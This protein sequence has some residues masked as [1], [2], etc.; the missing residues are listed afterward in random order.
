MTTA[1]GPGIGRDQARELARRELAR[2]IYR[3]SLLSR[4]GHDIARWLSSLFNPVRGGELNWLALALLALVL[5]MAVIAVVYWLGSPAGGRRSPPAPV[6]GGRPQTAAQ[7]RSAAEQLA[8]SGNYREAIVEIVRA[9]AA[10]LE[11]RDILPPKPART[12]DELA[13][14]AG[15]AF[16]DESAELMAVTRLF[17]EV[18]YGGRP[19]S[20]TSYDRARTLDSR[21][22]SARP[23]VRDVLAATGAP[24]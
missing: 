12:A 8:A 21:L 2:S 15:L 6:L 9:T 16:P 20:Q 14:E 3:P 22:A 19:G 17:D 24:G 1:S 18:L 23:Q 11:A 7:Y 5:A 13:A 4:V 10:D